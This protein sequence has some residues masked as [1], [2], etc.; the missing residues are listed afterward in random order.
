MAGRAGM[1]SIAA[2]KADITSVRIHENDAGIS[3][4]DTSAIGGEGRKGVSGD[5][6]L[7]DPAYKDVRTLASKGSGMAKTGETGMNS[8]SG[9]TL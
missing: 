4:T 2:V 7:S 9:K 1:T 3:G 5:G 8:G 6:S